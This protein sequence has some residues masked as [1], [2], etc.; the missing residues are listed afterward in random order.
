MS[1]L[2]KIKD[3]YG[4]EYTVNVEMISI[5]QD[6]DETK[7]ITFGGLGIEVTNETYQKLI[8][9][10]NSENETKQP[11]LMQAPSIELKATNNIREIILVAD[12]IDAEAKLKL[13]MQLGV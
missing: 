10:L 12:Y 6:N 5:I 9:M 1:K 2:L 8:D 11:Q 7:Y 13:L 4:S 3:K